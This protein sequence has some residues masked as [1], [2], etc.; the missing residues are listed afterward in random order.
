MTS[1]VSLYLV[2][3]ARAS[4]WCVL[5]SVLFLFGWFSV[6]LL[7]PLSITV[8]SFFKTLG[9]LFSDVFCCCCLLDF[10]AGEGGV[11]LL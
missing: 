1:F 7:R 9:I 10:F 4:L 6:F 5:C 3:P 8:V 2:V 11:C